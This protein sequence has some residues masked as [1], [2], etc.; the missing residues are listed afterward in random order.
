MTL[1]KFH[2]S[3]QQRRFVACELVIRARSYYHLQCVRGVGLN[4][5]AERL[6][7]RTGS[8][9]PVA[10]AVSIAEVDTIKP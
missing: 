8:T 6:K 10:G 3:G 4:G 1:G 2:I 5:G 9:G 7:D